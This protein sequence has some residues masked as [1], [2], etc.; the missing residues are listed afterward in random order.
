MIAKINILPVLQLHFNGFRDRQTGRYLPRDLI[1]FYGIP[2]LASVLLL[3]YGFH[4]RAK[5]VDTAI[6]AQTIFIPLLVNV[7]V[8]VYAIIDKVEKRKSE[9]QK[10]ADRKSDEKKLV[11]LR[12]LYANISYTTLLSGI[13]LIGLALYSVERLPRWVMYANRGLVYFLIIHLIL[14]SLMIVKRLHLLLENELG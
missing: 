7:L 13:C 2:V 3:L 5:N 4:V 1:G 12:E 14:T 8:I 6:I 10:E 9:T 11:L